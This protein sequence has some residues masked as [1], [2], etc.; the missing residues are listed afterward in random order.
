MMMEKMKL[1]AYGCLSVA[2]LAVGPRPSRPGAENDI[3]RRSR[4]S[5][6]AIQSP[7]D[8]DEPIRAKAE[9]E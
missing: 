2:V 6:V 4:T 5:A 7:S 3:K 9:L 1:L 8:L